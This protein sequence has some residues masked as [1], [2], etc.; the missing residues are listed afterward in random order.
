MAKVFSGLMEWSQVDALIDGMKSRPQWYL[1]NPAEGISSAQKLPGEEGAR[2]LSEM[3]AEML[4]H[5]RESLYVFVHT[6]ENPTIIKVFKHWENGCGE[7][8]DPHWMFSLNDPKETPEDYVFLSER[9]ACEMTP[10][11][12]LG[13]TVSRM[14][15]R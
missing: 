12:R 7:S 15:G 14:M 6:R 13:R 2:R 1:I 10:M 8:V 3:K 9:A 11:Q 4:R 5:H